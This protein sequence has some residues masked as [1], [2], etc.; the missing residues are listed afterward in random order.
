MCAFKTR[1]SGDKYL[2][3]LMYC[4]L[5][6]RSTLLKDFCDR[7]TGW[8]CCSEQTRVRMI[9]LRHLY[10]MNY[11]ALNKASPSVFGHMVLTSWENID[12]PININTHI[13]FYKHN[14]AF[15]SAYM[16]RIFFMQNLYGWQRITEYYVT[17]EGVANIIKHM[18]KC[19][20]LHYCRRGALDVHG[21]F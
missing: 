8:T 10:R 21:I 5:V 18:P 13:L 11:S 15:K 16:A 3:D 4:Y 6:I 2:N 12:I 17:D 14:D 1:L 7:V 19:Y 20:I 9:R